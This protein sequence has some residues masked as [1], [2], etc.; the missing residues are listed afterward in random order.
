[1]SEKLKMSEKQ[2]EQEFNY[3]RISPGF[4][5]TLLELN[6]TVFTDNCRI[7]NKNSNYL[8]KLCKNKSGYIALKDKHA[9][10]YIICD[11]YKYPNIKE[12]VQTIMALGVLEPYRGAG[13]GTELIK[14]ALSIYEEPLYEPLYL[15]VRTSSLAR[16]LYDKLQFKQYAICSKIYKDPVEDG[17]IMM[18]VN[19]TK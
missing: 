19:T 3:V 18:H 1:M 7:T 6:N 11:Q 9:V 10:G 16:K 13:I 12:P 5:N 15:C 8:A 4:E 17:I 2:K 14:R